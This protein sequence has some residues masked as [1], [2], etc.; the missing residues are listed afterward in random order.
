MAHPV[1]GDVEVERYGYLGSGVLCKC[2]TTGDQGGGDAKGDCDDTLHDE[3]PF[4]GY[5][6]QVPFGAPE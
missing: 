5:L 2:T 3:P 1:G 6:L 4:S